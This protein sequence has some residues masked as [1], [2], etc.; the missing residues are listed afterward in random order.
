MAVLRFLVWLLEFALCIFLIGLAAV[1]VGTLLELIIQYRWVLALGTLL[2]GGI[3]FFYKRKSKKKREQQIRE[4]HAIVESHRLSTLSAANQQNLHQMVQLGYAEE[5]ST[6]SDAEAFFGSNDLVRSFH[7]RVVGVTYDNDDG[8]SRQEILSRC[9]IGEPVSFY[10]HTFN[11][12][13]A[14]AV[15][16]DHGQIGY[17]SANLAADLDRDYGSDDY[18]FMAHISSITG[19]Y[20]G[21]GYGCNLLLAIYET[22]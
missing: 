9:L 12:A 2:A 4:A 6:Q 21:C 14:C 8:S 20:D 16:S 15:I 5:I 1:V 13:P 11:G 22:I 17:L 3:Y 18:C 19:G 7:T 10:W